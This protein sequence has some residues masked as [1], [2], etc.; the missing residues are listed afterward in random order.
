M[1]VMES[2]RWSDLISH[3]ETVSTASERCVCVYLR[4]SRM[5]KKKEEDRI[6][7]STSLNLSLVRWLKSARG[8]FCG[9]VTLV[10]VEKKNMYEALWGTD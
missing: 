4:S 6:A 9:H 5:Q 7:D 2:V 8:W 10:E 3:V 1:F